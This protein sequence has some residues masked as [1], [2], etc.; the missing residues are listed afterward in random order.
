MIIDISKYQPKVDY[1]KLKNEV[2]GVI[3]RAVSTDKNG[4]Y[5]DP[6]FERHYKGCKQF[7]IPVGA[8]FFSYACTNS[9]IDAELDLFRKAIAGKTFELPLVIDYEDI[10]TA[11]VAGKRI[12]T[13]IVINALK[14]IENWGGYAMYYTSKSFNNTLLDKSRLTTYD[15][16]LAAW[17]KYKPVGE[18][19]GLW[20]YTN[21]GK[22][23]A[24]AGRVDM[25]RAYKNYPEI[26]KAAGLNDF[27]ITN[28]PNKEE[29]IKMIDEY[30]KNVVDYINKM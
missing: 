10:P 6:Y 26:I 9:I 25:S 2:D 14:T 29:L 17:T 7:N 23:S 22:L 15:F 5:I 11:K 21:S 8:Y 13:D 19:C 24:I 18:R 3:I 28:K 1:A 4:I 30:Y 16:W 20:Q 12:A 27:R